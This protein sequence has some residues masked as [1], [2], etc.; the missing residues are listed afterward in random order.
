L[1]VT[2]RGL[3]AIRR[4]AER[5]EIVGDHVLILGDASAMRAELLRLADVTIADPPY[6]IGYKRG[7]GGKGAH[8]KGRRNDDGGAVMAG[9]DR[10][11]D[12]RPW[13]RG[14]PCILWGANHYARRVPEAV[15][16]WLVW[17]KL[18]D[19]EPWDSFSDVEI[20]WCSIKGK[21]KLFSHLW[22][23]LAQA[24]AGEKRWHKTAKPVALMEWCIA[25]F[26]E[27]G[28]ILDPF[29][30]SATT[31]IAAHRLGRRF[32]GVEIDPATFEIA[33]A[34]MRAELDRPAL[35]VAQPI[36]QGELDL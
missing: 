17:N 19:I 8:T 18:G 29:M 30:G 23:G 12:P 20:A 24:G 7:N 33:V 11:F 10:P 13:I 2:R 31:G 25:F 21:D 34:R 1:I 6:G 26:P 4:R 14:G 35:F 28:V 27:A 15:G 9:D 5:V 32:V 22:K 3:T 16:R 36:P